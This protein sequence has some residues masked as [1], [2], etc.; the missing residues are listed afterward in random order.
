MFRI[1]ENFWYFFDSNVL[2]T[3]ESLRN[4]IFSKLQFFLVTKGLK[5]TINN[6]ALK[7]HLHG[8]ELPLY[9]NSRLLK[10]KDTI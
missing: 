4:D 8:Y 7:L 1:L 9:E 5:L 2:N 6:S 10:D 3:I